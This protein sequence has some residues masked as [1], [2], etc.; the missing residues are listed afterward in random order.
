M[1]KTVTINIAGFVYHIDEDAFNKLDSYLNAVRGSIQQEG[2]EEIIA[3]IEGRIGELFSERVDQQTGVIRMNHVDEIINIMGKPEDYII[4]DEIPAPQ[5]F[6]S[7]KQPK[8]IYRDGEKRVFG[9]VCSGIGHYLNVDPVWIRIIFVLLFFLY[10]ISILVYLILWI[11]I[12]KARNTSEILEMLGEPVTISNIEKRFKDGVPV[13]YSYSTGSSAATIIRK[14]IGI[15]LIVFS[16]ISIFGSFFAPLAFNAQKDTIFRNV[17]LYN[18]AQIGIPFWVL[19]LSLFLVSCLPFI[20]L[21]LLGIKIL[22]P[23]TKHIGLV[24][25]ILGFFWLLAIFIFAYC[26]INAD[27]EKDKIKDLF[28]NSYETKFTK[29]DLPL[30]TRDTLNLVFEKDPRIFNVNDTIKNDYRYSEIQRVSV[31][32]LESGIGK[33]YVEVEEKTFNSKRLNIKSL[34]KYNIEIESSKFSHTLNYNY[35]IKNDTLALSNS[36]LAT[37]NN[38]TEDNDVRVKVY[39]TPEQAIKLNGKDSNFIW[40]QDLEEGKNIYRFDKTGTLKST[41]ETIN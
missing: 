15:I 3:D 18:E 20:V 36:I 21:L 16:T 7:S 29:A 24:S 41:T 32:I 27:F 13:N 34:G 5:Q 19:N 28:D 8:K 17:L 9:G 11:V 1:N 31:E 6:I 2:E 23:K 37:Y 22:K 30:N 40:Y 38:F 26:M 14:I 4:D 33:A 25:G 12:P 10:G 39:I 35:S